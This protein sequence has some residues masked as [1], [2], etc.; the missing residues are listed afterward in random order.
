MSTKTA[1]QAENWIPVDMFPTSRERGRQAKDFHFQNDKTWLTYLV[2]YRPS[3]SKS[4]S[5]ITNQNSSPESA[6]SV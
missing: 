1:F 3:L 2:T 4:D 6:M 5:F